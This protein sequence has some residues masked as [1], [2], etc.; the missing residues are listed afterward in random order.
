MIM[1]TP[2]GTPVCVGNIFIAFPYSSAPEVLTGQGYGKEVDLWALGVILYI[3]YLLSF[4]VH[5]TGFVD[6]PHF[7][8]EWKMTTLRR[9]TNR[10]STAITNSMANIGKAFPKKVHSIVYSSAAKDLVSNLLVI[11]P[12]KRL[13][14]EQLL[15]HPWIQVMNQKDCH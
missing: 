5:S 7:K 8:R 2:C 12:K 1:R 15:A 10:F 9:F 14:C 13:T 3:M 4:F 11:D 6:I